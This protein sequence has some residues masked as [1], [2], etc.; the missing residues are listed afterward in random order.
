MLIENIYNHK[1]YIDTVNYAN[2][3]GRDLWTFTGSMYFCFT[4]VTTIGYGDLAPKT[5]SGRIFFMF[6]VL[7]G[8]IICGA[9][10][11]E[12][13]RIMALVL[14]KGRVNIK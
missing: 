2:N 8:M 13:G 5:E 12:L 7:P 4:I 11:G 6:Y 14:N 1:Q 3:C 9:V 10:I